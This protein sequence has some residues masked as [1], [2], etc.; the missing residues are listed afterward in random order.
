MKPR[1]T[2][3]IR[4]GVTVIVADSS[5]KKSVAK[6]KQKTEEAAANVGKS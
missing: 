1:T 2:V 3:K 6:Q 4:A 5:E